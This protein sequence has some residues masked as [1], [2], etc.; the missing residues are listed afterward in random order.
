M[1]RDVDWFEQALTEAVPK[2]RGTAR[3]MST[4]RISADDLLQETV[5]RALISRHTFKPGTN[6]HA[7]LYTV[8]RTAR[9]EL[10]RRDRLRSAASLDDPEAL[11]IAAPFIDAGAALDAKAALRAIDR[12][13]PAARQVLLLTGHGLSNPQI[14]RI[15][16][17]EIGTI[18]SRLSRARAALAETLQ[19]RAPS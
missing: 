18:K 13:P 11:E 1:S 16:L 15:Q 7:W 14:A 8:M 10:N 3:S 17:V 4:P 6:M 9:I 5:L 12:L 2:L 19:L